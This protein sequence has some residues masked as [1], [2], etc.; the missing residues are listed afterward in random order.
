MGLRA[1]EL[2]TITGANVALNDV[3][4]VVDVSDTSMDPTGT[5][6]QITRSELSKAVMNVFISVNAPVTDLITYVWYQLNPNGTLKTIWVEG[7]P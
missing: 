4:V 7:G 3:V 1:T 6:K 5:N 2:A